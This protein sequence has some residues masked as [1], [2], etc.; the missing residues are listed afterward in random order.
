[1]M[2]LSY[3]NNMWCEQSGSYPYGVSGNSIIFISLILF[4]LKTDVAAMPLFYQKSRMA[5]I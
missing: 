3:V 2:M 5:F 4:L 1:M